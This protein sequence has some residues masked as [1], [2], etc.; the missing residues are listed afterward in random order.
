[1]KNRR[2]KPVIRIFATLIFADEEITMQKRNTTTT[3]TTCTR[4][5]TEPMQT[6]CVAFSSFPICIGYGFYIHF[7]STSH[8]TG[9]RNQFFS[10]AI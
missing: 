9:E 2:N 7:L 6:I 3:A 8:T 10:L 5:H 1:M 4:E